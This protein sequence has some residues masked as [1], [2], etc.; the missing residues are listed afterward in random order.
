MTV[1]RLEEIAAWAEKNAEWCHIQELAETRVYYADLARCARA[2]VTVKAA[3]KPKHG[4]WKL[5]VYE[6][7]VYLSNARVGHDCPIEAV[8][9]AG[10]GE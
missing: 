2:W 1:E 5:Q 9:A 8:E 6:D 7:G 3:A 10:G 4:Q